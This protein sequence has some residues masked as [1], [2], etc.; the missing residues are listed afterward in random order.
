[1][2][3]ALK[4]TEAGFVRV[5]AAPSGPTTVR[6]AVA[7]PAGPQRRGRARVFE[8]WVQVGT[9][10]SEIRGT[11]LGLPLVR[12]LA[13]LLGGSVA[14]EDAGRR[15]DVRRR[16]ALTHPGASAGLEATAAEESL[17]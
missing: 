10:H 6:F 9:P 4:V 16:P 15:R 12:R 8:E 14:V 2:V 7:D 11:R 1:M 13:K 17:G 3:D 5:T